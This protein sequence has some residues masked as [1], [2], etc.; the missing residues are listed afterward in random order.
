MAENQRYASVGDVDVSRETLEMLMD[1][2][3]LLRKWSRKINLVSPSTLSAAW[4]RHIED[5]A[6][7]LKFTSEAPVIWGDL[8]SGG[9]LPGVVL[10]ILLKGQDARTDLAMVEADKRKA[11]FLKLC[12]DRYGL[13]ATIRTARIE[14]TDPLGADVISA[15]ALAP[16]NT[17][18]GY[19]ERHLAPGG[20][21]IL[22]KG[23]LFADEID[24][25]KQQWRYELTSNPSI[26]DP[27]ARILVLRD[28]QRRKHDG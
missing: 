25:A 4:S 7:I 14:N 19:V 2:E 13:N 8:G 12:V 27:D 17:L 24:A 5:S 16:L 21:A 9:G 11:A 1:F 28:L 10:G 6:Q 20:M 3:H 18:L 15:R 23:R 26:I 22:P